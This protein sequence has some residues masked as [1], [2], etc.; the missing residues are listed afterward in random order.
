MVGTELALACTY[1]VVTDNPKTS[2]A[3][4]EV[5]LGIFP[6]WGGT[7]RLPRLIGITEALNMILTG[8]PVN[9]VKAYKLKLADAIVPFELMDIKFADFLTLISTSRERSKKGT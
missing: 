7:Q 6:G 3:L 2:I 4:P 1:R 9:A 5:S 8:K